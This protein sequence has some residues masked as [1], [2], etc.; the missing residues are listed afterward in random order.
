MVF[1]KKNKATGWVSWCWHRALQWRSVTQFLSF[2]PLIPL[3]GSEHNPHL[4]FSVSKKQKLTQAPSQMQRRSR[5]DEDAPARLRLFVS[6]ALIFQTFCKSQN[7]IHFHVSSK[8]TEMLKASRSLLVFLPQTRRLF[9]Q[10][11]HSDAQ[12]NFCSFAVIQ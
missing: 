11:I 8:T 12:S 6:P 7:I 3:F 10:F 2:S 9:V 5:R 1:K 4:F